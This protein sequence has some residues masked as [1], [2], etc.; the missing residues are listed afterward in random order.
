M[1]LGFLAF[2]KSQLGQKV[3]IVAGML[4]AAFIFFNWYGN[5]EYEKGR[6]VEKLNTT[7]GIR[8][9]LEKEYAAREA[10]LKQDRQA[11]NVDRASVVKERVVTS[12]MRKELEGTLVAIRAASTAQAQVT[13]AFISTIP[14][15]QLDE[16]IRRQ[17]A[18][19]GPPTD[20]Q[21]GPPPQ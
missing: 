4:L 11:L 18:K 21:S 3:L 16:Y 5:K 17:S 8:K 1:L 13:H 6:A 12:Q 10:Q 15:D 14:G 7:E 2:A 20:Q 9:E 19:L